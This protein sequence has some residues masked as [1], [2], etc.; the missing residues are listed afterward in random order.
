M[1]DPLHVEGGPYLT[2][3]IKLGAG[4]AT[5]ILMKTYG[6]LEVVNLD[7]V[8]MIWVRFDGQTA[9]ARKPDNYVVFLS[10]RYTVKNATTRVCLFSEH[11]VWV[12]V[13]GGPY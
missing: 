11:E 5:F 12:T 8:G 1:Q 10:R 7:R 6:A 2:Y 4:R 13:E 9:E 3:P